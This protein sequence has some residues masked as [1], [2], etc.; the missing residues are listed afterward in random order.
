MITRKI[1]EISKK[2]LDKT[3]QTQ[4]NTGGYEAF[5]IEACGG[6]AGSTT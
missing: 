6:R 2:T 3:T 1:E 5:G 4:R